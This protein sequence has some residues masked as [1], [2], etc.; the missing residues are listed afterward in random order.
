MEVTNGGNG[1]KTPIVVTPKEEMLSH[2][3]IS[4]L[5]GFNVK[6]FLM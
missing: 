2:T 1:P 4:V 5:I 3:L 6:L